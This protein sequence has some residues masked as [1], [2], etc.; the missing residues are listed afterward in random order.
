MVFHTLRWC[1]VRHC[2][3]FT[4][5]NTRRPIFSSICRQSEKKEGVRWQ[6][7]WMDKGGER[8][9]EER[10][11]QD[12]A[13]GTLRR[14]RTP[15]IL[16]TSISLCRRVFLRLPALWQLSVPS[17]FPL[18]PSLPFLAPLSIAKREMGRDSLNLDP[19]LMEH[20]PDNGL[21]MLWRL[22]VS[23]YRVPWFS[24]DSRLLPENKGIHKEHRYWPMS[25]KS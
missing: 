23:S 9:G 2:D 6:A 4:T 13:E 20:S 10:R 5:G 14:F 16:P 8:W 24:V 21:G 12:R 3:G 1:L 11:R 22:D 19:V 7:G 15:L 17:P 25:K 18:P